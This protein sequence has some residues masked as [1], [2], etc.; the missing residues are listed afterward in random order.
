MLIPALLRGR[1]DA[2]ALVASGGETL[3]YDQLDAVTAAHAK[4]LLDE[5]ASSGV[6][7]GVSASKPMEFLLGALAVWRAGAVL[8]PLDPRGGAK[9]V[10]Q[11][12][13]RAGVLGIV[14]GAST[15][16]ELAFERATG[17]TITEVDPR[18]A[19]V[20]FTSG[21]S[22]APKGVVLSGAGIAANIEAI[23][24]YLPV[25]EFSR[26][27]IT[28]PLSYSYALVG[29]ALTTLA[30][31][32]TVLLLGDLAFPVLQI[33][34]MHRLRASGFSSVPTSLRQVVRVLEEVP[35]EARPKLGYVASAGG[36]LD[37]STAETIRAAFPEA[38][39]FN[40]YGLTE[41]SPRVCAIE[42]SDPKFASGSVGRPLPGLEVFADASGELL[43]RGPSVMLGYLGDPDGTA[44]VLSSDGVLRTGDAG[45]VD[46]DGYVFVSGRNDGVVKCA[47]ER[48]SAEEVA[49]SL[50]AAA[51]PGELCVIAVP[52]AQLGAK[53]IAFVE[54]G[55]ERVEALRRAAREEL[56]PAKRPVR[57]HALE[58][59]PRTHN[60]KFDLGALRA[61]AENG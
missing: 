52:D 49:A 44:R 43:V 8:V 35:V 13:A 1:P 32:G 7:V 36:M 54:G 45:R 5:G 56:P 15:T 61:L 4:R 55:Q 51:S 6:P 30:A 10:Q 60:G 38:R 31:G 47:G 50:R 29:Q 42:V 12:A 40:Q 23:L 46:E 53:L 59:L 21:S 11:V 9:W 18:A 14:S 3:S 28:L 22:G 41:A 57:V 17:V 34:A 24:S 19:M 48:V 27:A 2:P 20:L 16:G 39:F 26:T 37:A 25:R 33:Q 58:A